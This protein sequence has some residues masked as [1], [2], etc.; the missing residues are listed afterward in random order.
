MKHIGH[1][2]GRTLNNKNNPAMLAEIKEEIYK[3][4]TSHPMFSSEW[5]SPSIRE[6]FEAMYYNR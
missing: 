5:V 2:L 4:A 6:E 3:I 1:L